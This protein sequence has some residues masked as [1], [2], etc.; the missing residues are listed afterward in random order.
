MTFIP[1]KLGDTSFKPNFNEIDGRLNRASYTGRY[2][3]ANHYPLNPSGRT[4]IVGRGF[5]GR[6]GPNHAA[7]SLLTRW[8]R[9]A[10]KTAII[11]PLSRR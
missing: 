5:L 10:N 3:I 7:D 8:S 11:D 9:D 6:W 1:Q 2:K 4:G